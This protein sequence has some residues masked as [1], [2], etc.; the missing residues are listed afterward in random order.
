LFVDKN[1]GFLFVVRGED[2]G[3]FNVTD[4]GAQ[5]MK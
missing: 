4:V 1:K 3:F 5:L 2:Q